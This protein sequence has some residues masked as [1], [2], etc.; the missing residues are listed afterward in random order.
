MARFTKFSWRWAHEAAIVL[1]M[2]DK[3]KPVDH[4]LF[5]NSSKDVKALRDTAA[6]GIRAQERAAWW[7]K[8]KPQPR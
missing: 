2:A 5:R 4:G 7:N 6:K 8:N 3:S 1:C